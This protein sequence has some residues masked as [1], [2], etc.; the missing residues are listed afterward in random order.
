M[1]NVYSLKRIMARLILCLLLVMR[2]YLAILQLGPKLLCD[3]I[4]SLVYL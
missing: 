4:N 3:E 1:S 2:L